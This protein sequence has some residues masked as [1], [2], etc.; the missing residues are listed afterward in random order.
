MSED[1]LKIPYFFIMWG[2]KSKR[3]YLILDRGIPVIFRTKR[4]AYEYYK[5]NLM[6]FYKDIRKVLPFVRVPKPVKLVVEIIGEE[7]E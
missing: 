7:D 6:E 5:V 1:E 3:G 2:L 4:E